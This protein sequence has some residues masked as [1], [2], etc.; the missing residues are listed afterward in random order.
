MQTSV[1]PCHIC[2]AIDRKIRN[3][4]W[5]STNDCRKIHLVSW[6]EVC[7][8]KEH[9]GLGLKK[10]RDLNMA[11]MMKLAFLFFKSP[12]E[13]WVQV[14]QH[15]Y[16]REGPNG[17][18]VKN[19]SRLSPLWR[20][21]KK[22]TPVMRLG[23]RMGL[24]DG[25]ETN[26]WLD[27]WVDGG[28][29]LIDLTSGSSSGIDVDQPVNAFVS[30]LGEWNW[31]LFEN[32]LS[33]DGCLQV[34]G[35]SPPIA[36]AGE[37]RITWGLERDGRFSIRSAYL[38][39]TEEE[40]AALDPIWRLIW[41]WKGPQRIR[42]FLWLVAHNR[43]LTNSE[44]HRRHLA[45]FGSCQVCPGHEESVLHVLRD[46]PLASATWELLALSSGDQTFFQTPLLP[47]IE[48]FLRK[49]ELCLLFGVT[50]WWL[51][52]ARNDRV[53]NN[54]LTTADSLTRHIQVWVAL[55]GDTLE[56]DQFI[57]HTGP[58]TRT[59]ELIAWEPAP[60]EW[61]TLGKCSITR[62]ELRGAVSGLQL[63]WEQGYRK[64]QLQLDSQCAVQLLQREGL[65]DHAH[66]ATIMTA[67]E[68]LR[69]NWEVQIL[70][71][72]R[73]SNHAADFLANIGH[74][75]PLGFHSIEQ[76]DPNLYYWLL[77]DQLGVSEE[78]LILNER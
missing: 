78:R 44:R 48:R 77:Y 51:W 68:L 7:K 32:F 5:G 45:E 17:L 62:A 28:E 25:T 67:T 54:K 27:R 65:E 11:F 49:P 59:G 30:S 75:C 55:V 26:F 34:A 22:V 52:R 6:D 4:M 43:L 74:S 23:M 40:S 12:N 64:I 69:R 16:F 47:W 33:R 29:R 10:A 24:R 53:F 38:L 37:D 39:I 8:P 9:G 41:R 13:L 46:C 35:M 50:C 3:F 14:L 18:Q 70:H 73:E 57:S 20:A 36:G 56:R 60:P 19:N 71:V 76:S 42:Q 58:P 1:L 2:E 21:V 66:A 15:K 61:V 63:A 72:Y 31:S